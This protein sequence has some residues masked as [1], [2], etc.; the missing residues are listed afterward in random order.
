MIQTIEKLL[1]TKSG[2]VM[3]VVIVM[4]V[5]LAPLLCFS[6]GAKEG[7]VVLLSTGMK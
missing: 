7:F 3:A 6:V 2:A 4:V 1:I 5:L